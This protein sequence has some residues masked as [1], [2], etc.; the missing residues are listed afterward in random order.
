MADV[1]QELMLRVRGDNSGADKAIESTKT[2]V[3][4]LKVSGQKASGALK[5]FSRE[6]L[7]AKSGADVA[8]WGTNGSVQNTN[9]S[10]NLAIVE[11]YTS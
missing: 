2:A 8:T 9:G 4:G 3:E 10:L 6:L 7:Q 5:S 11:N 1:T